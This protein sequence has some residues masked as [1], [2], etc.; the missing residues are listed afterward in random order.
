MFVVCGSKRERGGVDDY[1][2]A[3]CGAVAAYAYSVA[4]G[5]CDGFP[6]FTRLGAEGTVGLGQSF[7][8]PVGEAIGGGR[9]MTRMR[10]S[11]GYGGGA[12]VPDI[13][14]RSGPMPLPEPVSVLHDR[15]LL[16]ANM[17]TARALVP[18]P[19]PVAGL[20]LTGK[21]AAAGIKTL[22]RE[23]PDLLLLRDPEGYRRALA[24]E[25]EPFVLDDDESQHLFPLSLDD[26]LRAQR[27]CGAD[28]AL[29][30]TGYLGA[31]NDDALRA[32]IR[33]ADRIARDDVIVSLPIDI[34][35]LRDDHIDHL[36]AATA[37]LDRPKAVLLG[38]QFDPMRRSAEAVQNLRRLVAEGGDVAV[39]RTDLTG[40][41]AMSHGAYATSLGTGGSLRHVIPFGQRSFGGGNDPSP[42]VLLAELMSFYKGSTLVERFADSRPPVCA[43]LSCQERPMDRFVG[44]GDTLDAHRHNV[45]VWA[46]WANDLYDQPT[47]DGRATWWKNLC[48]A[49]VDYAAVLN[50]RIRQPGAFQPPSTLRSWAEL[51]EWW[52]MPGTTAR[53]RAR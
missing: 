36:I 30:P 17:R 8:E 38:G 32:V 19:A 22:R 14:R 39:L 4:V 7:S 1:W 23:H 45:H 27:D 50:A 42:T 40:F 10:G 25:Q 44:R 12:E 26:Y 47:V 31:G 43:C 20:V 46:S 6:S 48:S 52:P 37:G 21:T 29:T 5:R 35:W 9:S 49:A 28:L 13:A 51:P 15:I 11:N 24:T 34:A 3:S 2:G 33:T 53:V 41:D 18:L 16:H